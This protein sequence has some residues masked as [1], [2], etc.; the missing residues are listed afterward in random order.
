MTEK[1]RTGLSIAGIQ[2]L[3]TALIA[4]LA[5][6]LC[7]RGAAPVGVELLSC[8]RNGAVIRVISPP[9]NLVQAAFDGVEYTEVAVPGWAKSTAPG[10]PEL[11]LTG[12]WLAL[13]PGARA[14][15]TVENMVTHTEKIGRLKPSPV[16]IPDPS[17]RGGEEVLRPDAAV[18][19]STSFYPRAWASLGEPCRQRTFWV[20]PVTVTPFRAQAGSGVLTVADTLTLRVSFKG[21]RSGGT[22]F[23]PHGESLA[24]ATILNYTQALGWREPTQRGFTAPTEG[25]GKYKLLVEEDGLYA[26]TYQDL[27]LAGLDP[28]TIENP[29]TIKIFLQGEEI[30]IR[31]EGEWDGSFDPDDYILF[32]GNFARGT[33]TYENIYTRA[34][35]YWLDWDGD[36]GLRLTERSVSPGSAVT[37]T[38][39]KAGIHLENDDIY[40]SFGM[41]STN[42]DIDHWVWDELDAAYDP[43]FSYVLELP[44]K[45]LE[46]GQTY[47]LTVAFRGE[48]YSQTVEMDHHV[49]VRWNDFLAIDTY[50]SHQ[51]AL[52]ASHGIATN[53]IY[54]AAPNELT[55]T[56]LPVEG[57]SV[58][59]F[60]LDW[61]EVRYWRDYS[62]INDTLYFRN[63]QDM[64]VGDIRYE[65][66]GFAE[67]N[68][69]SIELW[70]LSRWERLVDFEFSEGQLAFQDSASDTTY[71]F[72]AARSAWL[73]PQIVADEP[74]NW[75]SPDHRADYLMIT[76]ED[77][78]DALAP[79]VTHY[80]NR[81]LAVERIKVGDIY[82]EFSY[83]MKT[84]QAIFDFIQYAYFNYLEPK[85]AYVL[86][87]GDASWDYKGNDTLSY[88]DYVPTHSFLSEKWGETASDNW[89]VAVSGMNPYNLPD[90]YIGRFPVNS[91]EEADILVQKSIGY[92]QSPP[93]YWRTQV[94]FTNGAVAESDAVH[95]DSTAQNLID[96]YFPDWYDPP[97]VYAHPSPGN[98]QYLGKDADLIQYI[99]EGAAMVNYIGHAG[100]QM[101]ETLDQGEI[102]QLVN[103]PR[104][105]FVAAFS[106]FTG[107]FSNTTGFGETF[108]LQPGGGAVAYWSN[109][110]LGYQNNNY[111][112]NDYLFQ[113]LFDQDSLTFGSATA[114]A[115]WAYA[116]GGYGNLGDVLDIYNLLG[117]PAAEFIFQDPQPEDTLD[118]E[119]P[120]VTTD[121]NFKNDDFLSNPVTVHFTLYDNKEIE[122][123]PGELS[124]ELIY[125][126]NPDGYPIEEVWPWNWQ[127][128]SL[129]WPDTSDGHTIE[130]AFSDTLPDGKWRFE[131]HVEDKLGNVTSQTKRFQISTPLALDK[132]L[133]WPNPFKDETNFTFI[134]SH[135]AQ[136]TIKVYTVSGKLIY[137]WT[138]YGEAGYNIIPWSG[139]D[140]QG[141]PISNGTYLYKIIARSGSERAEKISKMVRL[142]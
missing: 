68:P 80:E 67:T 9:Y 127:S 101:W 109:T 3:R 137:V 81:G 25:L 7:A 18:Y 94:I 40:E 62:V 104:F 33:Y 117:D 43:E 35:V 142:R 128:D 13:P 86:L 31:V 99:N 97:R 122:T 23:D 103:S 34:N 57:V 12:F 83:G 132:A 71:Y 126:E 48:T 102:S 89:F 22:V 118:T 90:L 114:G 107:I 21:G 55:F 108:I 39:Y 124:L 64:G 112:I 2:A 28:A 44:G 56:A 92:A 133:N 72:V 38:S 42:D 139:R 105:P 136:L 85:P 47:D 29:E 98:E 96:N 45:V 131:I 73:T 32:Y 65:L 50:F 60:Y 140:R 115:K 41:A 20:V 91:P 6:P 49:Q 14:G 141:D 4:A 120:T 70:N 78:Y 19:S 53:Y 24:R 10:K 95:F 17:G 84:P 75:K 130:V 129:A 63:P 113:M 82:D 26:V 76:H 69:D 123:A 93:G 74:S 58:N 88:V 138:G 30:P 11:P 37:A 8:D 100:N 106:C 79:L 59:A 87:V 134:L 36:P 77:F 52:V 1:Q 119:P 135:D 15:L 27:E 61:F 66:T 16:K 116:T 51:N 46:A 54:D 110:A 125:A 121:P 111:V 5:L